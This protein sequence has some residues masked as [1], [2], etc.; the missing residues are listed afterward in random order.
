MLWLQVECLGEGQAQSKAEENE[1]FASLGLNGFIFIPRSTKSDMKLILM[2][3]LQSSR[4]F[5]TSYIRLLSNR[6]K[7]F[8]SSQV[9]KNKTIKTAEAS[10]DGFLQCSAH[11]KE[12]PSA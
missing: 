9:T 11:L 8:T 3:T 6:K 5:F 7:R 1:S 2:M 12:V 4:H 10:L